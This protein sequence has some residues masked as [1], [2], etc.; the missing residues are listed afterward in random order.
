M[1][2][3]PTPRQQAREQTM[4]RILEIARSQLETHG[5]A[6]LSLREV[7][8]ELGVVSSAVYRYVDGRDQLLTLLLVDAFEDLATAVDAALDLTDPA[9]QRGG[10]P[11]GE[12]A[13]A[14]GIAPPAR[15]QL[16]ELAQAMRSWAVAH[17]AQWTLLYGTPVAQYHAPAEATTY[18]GTRVIGRVL[19]I[20]VAAGDSRESDA[21]APAP[22]PVPAELAELLGETATELSSPGA[23]TTQLLA[24]AT[25]FS[26]VVGAINAELFTQWG[27]QFERQGAELFAAQARLLTRAVAL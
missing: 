16:L 10:E 18:P 4:Q 14:T 6:G 27:P 21:A 8:R 22:T 13:P 12:T 3:R 2:P 9:P 24:T 1:T 11:G 26:G 17:P 20:V 5:A 25:F 19:E 15:Q 7:A 23:T